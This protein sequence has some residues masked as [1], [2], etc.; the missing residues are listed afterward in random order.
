MIFLSPLVLVAIIGGIIYA[1]VHAGHR[2]SGHS[3]AM[4]SGPPMAGEPRT[5]QPLAGPTVPGPTVPGPTV[6]G[7]MP[8][9]MS[10]THEA[11]DVWEHAGLISHEQAAAIEAFEA[12]ITQPTAPA[13]T[14]RP[15]RIPLVAE[16]LGYLGGIL[17]IVGLSLLVARYWTD[18]ATAGRLSLSGVGAAAL[19]GAGYA[20]RER[21]DASLQRLRWFLWTLSAAAGALFGGVLA[22]NAIGSEYGTTVALT[23]ATVVTVQNGVLWAWRVRPIQQLFALAGLAVVAGTLAAQVGNLSAAAIATM[24]IGACLLA[25]G[26][27]RL[28][29]LPVITASVGAVAAIVGSAISGDEWHGWGMALMMVV[30]VGIVA[31]TVLPST[32]YDELTRIMVRIIGGIGVF[33]AMPRTITYF[34]ADAGLLT[35]LV[36]WTLGVGLVWLAGARLVNTPVVAEC[37]GGALIIAG[38]AITGSQSVAIATLFGLATSI[39]LIALGTIP[40]RVLMSLFGSLGL[41]INVPWSISHFFPGEGRAPLLIL[42]SGAVIV[43]V[44]VWL[45]RMGGRFRSELGHHTR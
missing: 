3:H 24:A 13:T 9:T 37:I 36:V 42:A 41:L 35:G 38:A 1:A 2:Q 10:R 23:I 25:A 33:Q 6:L 31:L 45:A 5:G 15:R 14:Q 4:P 12:T 32:R 39:C 11:V 43:A 8:Q 30:T 40:G 17:A 20:V 16:A 18:M 7:P 44:A 34:A 27:S 28:T 22:I 26:W 19:T 29:P 21:Q